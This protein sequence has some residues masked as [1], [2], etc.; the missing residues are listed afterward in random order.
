MKKQTLKNAILRG[1][2]ITVCTM[3]SMSAYAKD[4]C[5]SVMCVFGLITG[6]NSSEC[7]QAIEDYFSIINFHKGSPDLDATA[8]SRLSFTQQCPSAGQAIN[9]VSDAFGRVI[10]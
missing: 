6:Q 9:T 5:E 10:K 3:S 1:A 7:S 2:I 8:A 4:P